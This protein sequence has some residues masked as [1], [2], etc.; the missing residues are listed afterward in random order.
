MDARNTFVQ[1]FLVG[2]FSLA[3]A[4]SF[5]YFL[6]IRWSTSFARV[7]YIL[8]FLTLLIGPVMKLWKPKAVSTPLKLPWSWRSELGIWFTI[9]SAIHFYFV[10]GGR[11]QW[12]LL[13]A[14][15]GGVGGEGYGFSN[16]L[17]I[18]AL[19]WALVLTATSFGKV[20]KWL[21]VESWRW[22]HSFTYVIFYLITAHAIYF[23][24]FSTYGGGPDFFGYM[25][26]AMFFV[27][28]TLQLA[29]FAKTVLEQKRA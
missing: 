20:I 10:M 29:A 14:L 9:V 18:V 24:I 16:L 5:N 25:Y 1:H 19:V 21:G 27:I 26:V 4:F 12:N 13:K 2:V 28:V 17:G 23:Q 22:L 15:G 11:P 6:D 7:S 8:L 3:L